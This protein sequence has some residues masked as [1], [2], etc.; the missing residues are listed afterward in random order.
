MRPA[1]PKSMRDGQQGPSQAQADVNGRLEMLKE[2]N[3]L[4]Q[5]A[6][7]ALNSQEFRPRSQSVLQPSPRCL[8]SCPEVLT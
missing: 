1:L 2:G 8:R 7:E 3:E 5:E 6:A 4:E